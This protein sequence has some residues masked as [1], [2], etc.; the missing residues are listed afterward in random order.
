VYFTAH[1]SE[2]SKKVAEVIKY[3]KDKLLALLEGVGHFL[4]DKEFMLKTDYKVLEYL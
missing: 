4:L 3:Y 2:D 1:K